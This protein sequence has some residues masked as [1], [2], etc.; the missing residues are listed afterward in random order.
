MHFM[1]YSLRVGL[2]VD[3]LHL[4]VIKTITRK[5]TLFGAHV[6][7]GHQGPFGL[8]WLSNR[9]ANRGVAMAL[10]LT[11]YSEQTVS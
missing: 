10:Q 11:G 2:E 5:W 6:E 8:C 7:G 1:C 4:G 3:F 9:G